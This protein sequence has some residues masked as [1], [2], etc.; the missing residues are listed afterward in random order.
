M[1]DP[2]PDEAT[3]FEENTNKFIGPDPFT[4]DL[5]VYPKQRYAPDQSP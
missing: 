3:M 1:A 5:L 4:H 2:F